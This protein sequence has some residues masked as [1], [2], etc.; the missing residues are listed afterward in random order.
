[1]HDDNRDSPESDDIPSVTYLCSA[2][3]YLVNHC[4]KVG[5][6]GLESSVKQYQ[7]LF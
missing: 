6:D 2:K 3:Q 5:L 4:I 1:V 7:I